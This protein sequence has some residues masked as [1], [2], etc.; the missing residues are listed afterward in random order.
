M[1]MLDS[2]GKKEGYKAAFYAYGESP[3]SLHWVDYN[4][5]ATRYRNLVADLDIEGKSV[6]D[7]GCGMGYG[8]PYLLS[9]TEDFSYLGIDVVEEFISFAN[10]HYLGF[11]FIAA[12]CFSPAFNQ[13]ADIVI[14]S[15]V[16]N[17]NIPNWLEERKKMITK[18][19][20][21]ASETLAFNMAGGLTKI[22][23]DYKIAYADA[24][25]IADFC[26]SLTPRV[27]LKTDYHPRDFTVI[28]QKND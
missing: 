4:S 5:I 8:L 24:N 19:Y 20:S 22:P 17:A 16:M 18:L 6:M 12:D 21:L 28:L 9:K 2:A 13:Q 27:V 14:S 26:T 10:K 7:A 15:G 3:S 11:E 1:G 23:P 25:E